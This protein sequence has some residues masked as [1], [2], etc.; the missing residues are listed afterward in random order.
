M[1]PDTGVLQLTSDKSLSLVGP[2]YTL[3]VSATDGMYWEYS[4][5][6]VNIRDINNHAPV[7][8]DCSDYHP[9]IPENVPLRTLVLQVNAN[10]EDLGINGQVEYAIVQQQD[11]ANFVI[12]G[13]TGRIETSSRFDRESRRKFSI[14]IKGTDGGSAM[15]PEERL[16]G[17]CSIEVEITDVNDNR[18]IF[19]RTFYRGSVN[20]RA[21]IG[22]RIIQV[23]PSA[24]QN[25]N[26]TIRSVTVL[27][28]LT[29][30]AFLRRSSSAL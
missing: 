4:R 2:Y 10:D 7:F 5:I 16:E 20:E 27:D 22:H 25:N 24:M 6:K 11:G 18:P 12:G 8:K 17:S 1:D 15:R 30:R 21:E 3:N 13:K 14:L 29:L 26:N 28:F 23:R 19:D 9:S